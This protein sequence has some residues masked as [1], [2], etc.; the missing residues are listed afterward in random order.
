MNDDDGQAGL[1]LML[2]KKRAEGK[3][4]VPKKKKKKQK[5]R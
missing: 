1:A 4:D 3:L 2:K 5:K